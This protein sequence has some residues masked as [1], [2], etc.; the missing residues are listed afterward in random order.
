MADFVTTF[1]DFRSIN[2]SC[3]HTLCISCNISP[4]PYGIIKIS[5][6]RRSSIR[7]SAHRV[8]AKSS[9]SPTKLLS[10]ST[11]ADFDH[12]LSTECS[13][14]SIIFSFGTPRETESEESTSTEGGFEVK[15]GS[16]NTVE[17]DDELVDPIVTEKLELS[18]ERGSGIEGQQIVTKELEFADIHGD[19]HKTETISTECSTIL[20]EEDTPVSEREQQSNGSIGEVSVDERLIHGEVSSFVNRD[21]TAVES[22]SEDSL[23][24]KEKPLKN[25]CGKEVTIPSMNSDTVLGAQR[26]SDAEEDY[27]DNNVIDVMHPCTASEPDS[28]L[29]VDVAIDSGE[30][31]EEKDADE[32]MAQT[33]ASELYNILDEGKSYTL[34]EDSEEN[35]KDNA[36]TLPTASEHSEDDS[37]KKHLDEVNPQSTTS[38]ADRVLEVKLFYASDRGCGANI[39][40]EVIDQPSAGEFGHNQ[41]AGISSTTTEND[42]KDNVIETPVST[43]AE[44]EPAQ[45][46]YNTAETSTVKSSVMVEDIAPLLTFHTE[47]TDGDSRNNGSVE[48]TSSRVVEFQDIDIPLSPKT[49]MTAIS[50]PGL[51]LY[52]GAAML[53]HPSKALSG[54]EDAFFIACQNWLGVA[55][56]VGQWSLEGINAGLY[57][58]ELMENCAKIVSECQRVPVPEPDQVLIQ[59]AAE[60]RSPGSSTVLVAY[61]D[62]QVFHA[63]NIGDSGFIIIRNGTVLRRSSP[64]LHGFNF[65]LQI[66]RGEDAAALI[67]RYHIDLDEGDVIVT[68]TDGLFDNLYEQEIA[69][70][71]SKSLEANLKPKE[72]ADFLAMRAQEVGR[73]KLGRSPFADAAKAAGYMAYSGGK[74][75]DVTVIVSLVTNNSIL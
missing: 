52:S 16:A 61:F 35:I 46:V 70:I 17:K 53:P 23:E 30:D 40:V 62:G 20:K 75:D 9:E 10:E 34:A 57:A 69:L 2:F 33:T 68:A 6:V 41:D 47:S 29:D 36:V 72:I 4:K 67:E 73:S 44:S 71:I 37:G 5:P 32:V 50:T 56:G 26:S 13:D 43:R 8:F 48:D 65:P 7:R 11:H 18:E 51:V 38:E 55:D 25:S 28:V 19:D 31:S 49:E 39:N 3:F 22:V 21:H 58:Q 24:L 64:M 27:A 15:G 12:V 66:Q 14:G 1:L 54:G 45:D 74:L 60:A 59:S 63:V 42:G